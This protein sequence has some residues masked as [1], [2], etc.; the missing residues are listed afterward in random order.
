MEIDY[1]NVNNYLIVDLRDKE[2]FNKIHLSNSINI[3]FEKLIIYPEK[4]LNKNNNYLLICDFGIKSKKTS[5]ILN[6][7]GYHTYSLK[8]GI[9]SVKNKQ[10]D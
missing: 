10:E 7:M 2:E 1:N 5:E 8:N 6:K 4:Y 3:S 9:K